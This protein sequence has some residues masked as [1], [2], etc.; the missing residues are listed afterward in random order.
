VF[1]PPVA[2]PQTKAAASS[3]GEQL[4]AYATHIARSICGG[5]VAQTDILRRSTGNQ[6]TSRQLALGATGLAGNE[7]RGHDKQQIGPASLTGRAA[8]AGFSWDFSKIPVFSTDRVAPVQARPSSNA[9]PLP[10]VL[11]PKLTVGSVDD[12]LEREADR[13]AD[14]V[15]SMTRPSIG[16]GAASVA[17]KCAQC[18]EEDQTGSSTLQRDTAGRD[19]PL[20]GAAAP[21]AVT[22]VLRDPGQALDPATRNFMEAGFGFD[23]G[24]V[25]VHD[26]AKAA[27]SARDVTARAYTVG[28]HIAFGRGAYRPDDQ[29]GRK[30]L[31]HEL[32]HVVQQRGAEAA[33]GGSSTVRRSCGPQAIGEPTGCVAGNKA[34]VD[35]A[36]FRFSVNCDDW[37][38]GADAGLLDY[39]QTIPAGSNVEIHGY[40][41]VEGPEA[42]NS[43]LACARAVKAKTWLIAAGIAESRITRLVNHGATAG[44]AADRRSV[45]I[46]SVG[47]PPAPVKNTPGSDTPKAD[48]PK[49]DTPKVDT[50]KPGTPKTDVPK[51]PTG[52]A[53]QGETAKPKT[54]ASPGGTQGSVQAGL[55]DVSHYYTTPA[56][57]HDALHEWLFQAMAAY[58]RQ[59]H[60]KDKSGEERQLF[61][62]V[63]YSL[64]T[65][66]WTVVGGFQESFV[67]AL[68]ANLQ[69]SFWGQ[70]TA[71]SNVTTGSPQVALSVGSQFA[72]QPSDWFTLGAQLGIGPT[73]QSGTPNSIDRG[74]LFFLQIQ[75]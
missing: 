51:P 70:L 54:P 29:Q 27:A 73:A 75:K 57:P 14:Q 23:F 5:A 32:A 7:L 19:D 6:A 64:T 15:M 46:R 28:N 31:A 11:Q 41:S 20:A 8:A 40:A 63:Q 22:D 38:G 13:A 1:A 30:L 49:T 69:L 25:R 3:T 36:V 35:G 17:R 44:K 71:G 48:T 47:S 37:T 61:A 53:P 66:Q 21:N 58:T 74:A 60:G 9:A 2:K 65:K 16:A 42:F 43:N 59:K 33:I 55:G 34:F 56:G 67:I 12:P 24:G 68:P 72:W 4:S 39:A 18:T 50:P 45:V 26:D 52:G 10:G 62:Q